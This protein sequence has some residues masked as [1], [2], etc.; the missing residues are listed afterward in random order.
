MFNGEFLLFLRFFGTLIIVEATV[1]IMRGVMGNQQ[2]GSHQA[3]HVLK[4][5]ISLAWIPL[6]VMIRD[7]P[8]IFPIFSTPWVNIGIPPEFYDLY[9]IIVSFII[10]IVALATLD[11][12]YKI[13]KLQKYKV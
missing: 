11:D 8:E 5:V 12:V 2:P 9:K 6:L 7:R 1:N 3:L 13:I 10:V 4:I